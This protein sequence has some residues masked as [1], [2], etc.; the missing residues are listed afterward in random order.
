VQ[1]EPF[2]WA[3]DQVKAAVA[4][5]ADLSDRWSRDGRVELDWPDRLTNPAPEP[6]GLKLGRS[7]RR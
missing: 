5:L 7:G 4:A 6:A 3:D 1:P 2:P